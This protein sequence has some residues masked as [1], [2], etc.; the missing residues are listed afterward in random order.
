M[1]VAGYRGCVCFSCGNASRALLDAGLYVVD[2]SRHG[3]LD[4]RM[5]WTPEEIH[6]AWPDLFDATPGHLPAPLMVSLAEAYRKEL[7][8]MEQVEQYVVPT[9]SGETVLCLRIAYPG[10][11]FVAQYD[12]SSPSTRFCETAP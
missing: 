3:M 6:R 2:V 8:E 10:L 7:G 1:Q 4:A 11:L 12:D 9:G 5:W